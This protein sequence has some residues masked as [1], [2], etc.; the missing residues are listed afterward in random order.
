MNTPRTKSRSR[1]RRVRAG[2]L[3]KREGLALIIAMTAIAVLA[4][5]LAE[6]HENTGTSF[7]VANTGR[8]ALKAEMLARSSLD[9]T[10]MVIGRERQ[11]RAVIAPLYQMLVGRAPPQLPVW[12]VANDLLQ[13]FCNYDESGEGLTAAGFDLGNIEGLGDTGGEC[14][15]VGMAE[16]SKI[17]VSDPL[18]S[19]GIPAKKN[20]AMSMFSLM[21]GYHAPSPYD[22]L[23]ERQDSEGQFNTR[24]DIVSD[25]CD[26]WDYDE[27]RT[28]FDPGATEVTESGSEDDI[29][30]RYRTPY[31]AKNAPFDSIEELR[32]VR[33][34]T[35][36][37]WATF[38]Q[39]DPDNILTERLTIYGSGSLNPNEA[40]PFAMIARVC[41]FIPEQTLCVDPLEAA[42]FIQLVSTVRSIAP[43]PFF[44]TGG[45]FLNFIEGKGG[46]RELYPMLLSMLGADN[47]LM[48]RPVTIPP[49]IRGR[50]D[51]SFIT[52]AKIMTL[53][54]VGRAGRA[55]VKIRAVL[56]IHDRWTPPPPNAGTMPLLGIFHYYRIE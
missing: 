26:W 38:V 27:T 21:G 44:S 45:Q 52:E 55:E 37:F 11:I 30:R 29:Y 31:Y 5:L 1:K 53:R 28:V 8:D 6:M 40:D 34:V 32:L 50:M 54:A 20:L 13:P 33:G 12:R 3:R 42:K 7:A 46:P 39:P 22:A 4:V 17:N 35:D 9:L 14:E 16:N 48:F 43:L 24:L 18:L 56:N 47:A 23:F 2:K 36:D 19:D 51:S 25:I 15:I 49:A 10:R 41:S